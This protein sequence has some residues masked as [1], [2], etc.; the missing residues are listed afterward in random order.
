VPHDQQT[1]VVSPTVSN[2]GLDS[3]FGMLA[4][5]KPVPDQAENDVPQP[6]DFVEF[7][8]RKTNP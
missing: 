5:A 8:F 2:V 4:G 1:D 3:E 6:H 7:G